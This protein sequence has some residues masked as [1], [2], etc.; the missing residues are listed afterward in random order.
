LKKERQGLFQGPLRGKSTTI[1]N[2]DKPKANKDFT[3]KPRKGTKKEFIILLSLP[4]LRDLR[5]E[6]IPGR[7]PVVDVPT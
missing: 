7:E 5:G 6:Q 3:T 4:F 1:P 2:P